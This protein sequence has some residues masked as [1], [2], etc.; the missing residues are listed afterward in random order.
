MGT[1]FDGDRKEGRGFAVAAGLP[2]ILD[3]RAGWAERG[4]TRKSPGSSGD[5]FGRLLIEIYSVCM[6]LF[7][8]Q[9]CAR[10]AQQLYLSI[11]LEG[12]I[13]KFI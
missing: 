9:S 4:T 2:I 1:G 7:L 3:L 6:T 8:P 10:Q 5:V 12:A 11:A 13:W